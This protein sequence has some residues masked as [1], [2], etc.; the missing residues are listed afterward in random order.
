MTGFKDVIVKATN[1]AARLNSG[2][3]GAEAPRV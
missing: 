1:L 3:S 2:A